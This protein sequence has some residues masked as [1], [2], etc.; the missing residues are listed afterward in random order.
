MYPNFNDPNAAEFLDRN[1]VELV[2]ASLDECPISPPFNTVLMT[3]KQRY[4]T[5]LTDKGYKTII[6]FLQRLCNEDFTWRDF[7]EFHAR[8]SRLSKS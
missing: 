3:F 1:A 7:C 4:R 2:T 6:L 5:C 8:R